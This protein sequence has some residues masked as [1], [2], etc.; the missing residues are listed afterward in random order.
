MTHMET[1][2]EKL[3]YQEILE[4]LPDEDIFI[5]EAE[6][7]TKQNRI[8]ELEGSISTLTKVISEYYNNIKVLNSN[9]E[10]I[11][12]TLNPQKNVTE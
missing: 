4:R 2:P 11:L 6:M 5:I 9:S 1:T 8:T 10:R 12:T 3:T 7:Q